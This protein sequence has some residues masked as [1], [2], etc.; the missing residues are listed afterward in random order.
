MYSLTFHPAVTALNP[1]HGSYLVYTYLGE[2]NTKKMPMMVSPKREVL[3]AT[4]LIQ[5]FRHRDLRGKLT[6]QRAKGKNRQDTLSK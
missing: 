4:H 6:A 3:G 1:E 5:N 2:R